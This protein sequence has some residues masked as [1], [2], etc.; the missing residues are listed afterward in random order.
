MVEL[1]KEYKAILL[2][3]LV[4]AT[5]LGIIVNVGYF[6]RQQT[7]TREEKTAISKELKEYRELSA[8]DKKVV[9]G[10]DIV[11]A[12]MKYTDLYNIYIE[13]G[14]YKVAFRKVCVTEP[15]KDIQEHVH[16]A[17]YMRCT[18]MWVYDDL[19]ASTSVN[20]TSS[21]GYKVT[22]GGIGG[23]S[24]DDR[25]KIYSLDFISGV[26]DQYLLYDFDA[27]LIRWNYTTTMSKLNSNINSATGTQKEYLKSLLTS[28]ERRKDDIT[29]I[30]F[31]LKP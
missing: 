8:Y 23:S 31:V 19:N 11:L 27:T 28:Y 16:I 24:F 5:L 29:G 9:K 22:S 25:N 21:T 1:L 3:V 17:T 4:T 20:G 13:I 2:E 18:E 6:A 26:L 7:S 14:T 10:N 15:S 30:K 12:L